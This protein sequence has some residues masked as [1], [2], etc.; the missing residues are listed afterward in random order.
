MKINFVDQLNEKKIR[1]NENIIQTKFKDSQAF[2]KL[3]I[4]GKALLH[5]WDFPV[6]LSDQSTVQFN[7]TRAIF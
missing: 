6:C 1:A 4:R 5:H 2:L 7:M 3:E